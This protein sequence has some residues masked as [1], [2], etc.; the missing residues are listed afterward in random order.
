[1]SR[2]RAGWSQWVDLWS[3]E[4]PPTSL[5]LLR[6]LLAAVMLSDV[7]WLG[8]LGLPPA[9]LGPEEIG[10]FGRSAEHPA[11]WLWRWLPLHPWTPWVLWGLW[12]LSLLGVLTGTLTP[13]ACVIAALLSANL[14]SLVPAADRGID[15]L[16]R[17]VLWIL[18]LSSAGAVAS[19]D[20]RRRTGRW[21]GDGTAFPAWPRHLILLQLIVMYTAAGVSKMG[22][23]WLPMGDF[24]ALW[25]ILQDPAISRLTHAPPEAWYPLSQLA[26]AG[27]VAWEWST[28]L[29]LVV[30]W[31][32]H[33]RPDPRSGW[34]RVLRWRPELWWAGVG[35]CFHLGIAALLKLG[36]FP[37]AMIALYPAF[38]HPSDLARSRLPAPAPQVTP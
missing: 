23:R 34:G 7:L 10:G 25:I 33:R 19:V 14:A 1:M 13:I 26:T 3:H 8:W 6:I 21:I 30:L 5:A 2:L 36:I 27:T 16:S 31:Q 9:L 38:L 4:E 22:A 11:P 35:L 18:A 20:A 37:W 32:R 24:G 29:L 17:N 15:L 12:V 28:P